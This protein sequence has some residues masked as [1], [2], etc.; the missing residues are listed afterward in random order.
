MLASLFN[1][2]PIILLCN[3]NVYIQREK[4]I[5]KLCDHNALGVIYFY[6]LNYDYN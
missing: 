6:R 2:Y 3:T 5:L 1:G 4:L